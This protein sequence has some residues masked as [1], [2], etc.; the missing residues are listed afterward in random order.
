MTALAE[1]CFAGVSVFDVPP[2]LDKLYSYEIPPAMRG[3]IAVGDVVCV[4][5]GRASQKR[6][7]VV[8]ET[9]AECV[10]SPVKPIISA[11][12]PLFRLSAELIGLC[13]FLSE[14]TFCSFCD[15]ARCVLPPAS[16]GHIR[17]YYVKKAD[18]DTSL[19]DAAELFSMLSRGRV[20]ISKLQKGLA[21]TAKRLF[22]DGYL[23]KEVDVPEKSGSVSEFYSLAVSKNE[24]HELLHAGGST[25]IRSEQKREL[26]SV[27]LSSENE[28]IERQTL[29]RIMSERGYPSASSAL[30]ELCRRGIVKCERR[31]S[32]RNSYINESLQKKEPFGELSAEQ[33]D[34]FEK[35]EAVYEKG[36]GAVLLHGVTGS[37]KTTVIKAVIDRTL[38]DGRAVMLLV[39][40]IAL[41]PQLTSLFC[42]SFGERVAVVHSSLS[43]KERLDTYKRIKNGEA[44]IVLGTRSAVFAPLENIGAIIMDE[45]GEHSYRSES[46]PKYHARD[47]A[48]YRCVQNGAL[49]LLASATPSFESYSKACLGAY[50]LVELQSR[51]GKAALPEVIFADMKSELKSGNPS[52]I[53][54]TLRTHIAECLIKG[55]QAILFINRRGYN[56]FVTCLE[57]G[58]VVQCPHCSVSMT[59]HKSEFGSHDYMECHF[60]G[61]HAPKP[62]ICESCGSQYLNFLGFGTQRIEQELCSLFPGVRVLRMDAD[63]VRAS[64][65]HR[66]VVERFRQGRADILLGTQMV[67]KGHDF[68][69]VTLVGVVDAD[70]LLYLDDYRA[71]ERCFSLLTQ[72]FGR[73]GRSGKKGVAILQTTSPENE[74]LHFAAAQNYKEFYQ[75]EIELRRSLQFPPFC[76][77]AEIGVSSESEDVAVKTALEVFEELKSLHRKKY[78]DVAL[79]VFGP[80]GSGVFKVK[81]KFRMRLV[82]KLRANAKSRLFLRELLLNTDAD[83][84]KITI[85]VNPPRI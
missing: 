62:L 35:I 13:E 16:L 81:D 20:E 32:Y 29:L 4:P 31:D 51:Y 5:F 82:L 63:S 17:E 61:Y 52:P 60:C 85:D 76:D 74:V 23:E 2:S 22:C 49:L 30:L 36:A 79:Q 75:K 59:Y 14:R 1:P 18:F 64:N 25:R 6:Y 58:S 78:S 48:R 38:A 11:L 8:R 33:R 39:P 67:A 53:G 83:A 9:Y 70:S 37:G 24:A 80:F 66:D 73:A 50:T 12:G 47:A 41:T 68:P 7:A 84:K 46:T 71:S 69:N 54:H 34:A 57:C 56:N 15:V 26:L 3:D 45:E 72:V 42:A 77:I 40:E 10:Y 19:P 43:Q 44:D 65:S 21:D 55:E 28:P 27:L